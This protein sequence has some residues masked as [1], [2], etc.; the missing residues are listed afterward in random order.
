MNLLAQLIRILPSSYPDLATLLNLTDP[1]ADF[2]YNINHVQI[3]R[4]VRAMRRFQKI[5]LEEKLNMV[6]M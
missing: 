3:H 6:S 1:E 4:R 5:C 2:Y